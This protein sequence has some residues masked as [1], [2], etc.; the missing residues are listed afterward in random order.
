M[1]LTHGLFFL[2]REKYSPFYE[3]RVTTMKTFKRLK[4][5]ILYAYYDRKFE[6]AIEKMKKHVYDPDPTIWKKWAEVAIDSLR[7]KYML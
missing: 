2:S 7:K 6:R 3:R 1:E 4:N 5:E